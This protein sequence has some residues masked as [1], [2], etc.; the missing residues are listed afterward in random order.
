[1]MLDRTKKQAPQADLSFAELLQKRLGSRGEALGRR[2]QTAKLLCAIKAQ[3]GVNCY[4]K[5]SKRG[6]PRRGFPL[7]SS[8]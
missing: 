1:M 8:S 4:L 6:N 3:E 5:N 7:I 2:P